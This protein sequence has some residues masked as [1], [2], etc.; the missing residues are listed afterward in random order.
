MKPVLTA[1]PLWLEPV[2]A[3]LSRPSRGRVPP[4]E[5]DIL[6]VVLRLEGFGPMASAERLTTTVSTKGQVILPSAIRQRR[7]W[8]VYC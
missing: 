3:F 6:G 1:K 7:E 4:L 2:L 5:R 8:T